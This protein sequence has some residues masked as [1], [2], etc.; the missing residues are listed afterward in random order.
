MNPAA[1]GASSGL[2]S[3]TGLGQISELHVGSWNV[4]GIAEADFDLFVAQVSD[5]YP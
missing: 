2:N 4:A 5:H 3:L 1:D